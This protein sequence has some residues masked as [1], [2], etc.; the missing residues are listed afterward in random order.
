MVYVPYDG[1]RGVAQKCGLPGIKIQQYGLPVRSSFWEK[2]RSKEVLRKEL[3]LREGLPAILL[4]GGGDGV[5]RL[6]RIAKVLAETIGR[7]RGPNSGQIVVICGKNLS[8][9]IKLER[10]N[11]PVPVL[12]KT[13]CEQEE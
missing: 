3:G 8:L 5:G 11:W 9:L 12:L 7:E 10:R 13:L 2:S 1:V 6:G 4:V